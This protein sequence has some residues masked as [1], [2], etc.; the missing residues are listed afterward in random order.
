MT[1]PR[2]RPPTVRGKSL[3]VLGYTNNALS[4]DERAAALR[5]VV[6]LAGQGSVVV[7]HRVRPLAEV[8]DAWTDLASGATYVRQV[9]VP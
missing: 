6:A 2:C 4:V 8:A 9:L 5:A 7:E 1:P 3:A